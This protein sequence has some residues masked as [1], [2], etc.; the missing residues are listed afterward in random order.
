M[1]ILLTPYLVIWIFKIYSK[2]EMLLYELRKFHYI[3]GLKMEM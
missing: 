1:C 2:D 3:L